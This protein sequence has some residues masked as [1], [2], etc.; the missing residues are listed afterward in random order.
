[1]EE[2]HRSFA[3]PATGGGPSGG[4]TSE[5]RGG[6][7]KGR[8]LYLRETGEEPG[9][10]KLKRVEWETYPTHGLCRT[11]NFVCRDQV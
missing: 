9:V 4:T 2:N 8:D 3:L 10:I 7:D 5:K 6:D 1:M 11:G